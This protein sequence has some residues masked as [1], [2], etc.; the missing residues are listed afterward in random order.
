MLL[1]ERTDCLKAL[2]GGSKANESQIH[3]GHW[4]SSSC[5]TLRGGVMESTEFSKARDRW[6]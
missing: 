1:K 4:G 6:E 2:M 5:G 3:V